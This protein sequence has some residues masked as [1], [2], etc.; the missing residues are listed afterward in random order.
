MGERDIPAALWADAQASR[1]AASALHLEA[2]CWQ[3]KSEMTLMFKADPW[4]KSALLT[5][6]KEASLRPSSP[7]ANWTA[8]F[9]HEP[10][11]SA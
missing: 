5:A 6:W 1:A 8:G 9:E 11:S 4:L 3:M 2:S 10:K 7:T